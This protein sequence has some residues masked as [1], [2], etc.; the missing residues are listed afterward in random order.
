MAASDTTRAATV[1]TQERQIGAELWSVSRADAAEGKS[2]N[3]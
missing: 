2:G 3:V 1:K